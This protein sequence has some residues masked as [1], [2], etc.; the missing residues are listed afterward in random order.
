MKINKLFYLAIVAVLFLTVSCSKDSVADNSPITQEAN[1][2]EKFE[3]ES[4]NKRGIIF[5]GQL[6]DSNLLGEWN[7]THATDLSID[8][9]TSIK[10]IFTESNRVNVENTKD[11]QQC[12]GSGSIKTLTKFTETGGEISVGSFLRS[13]FGLCDPL[14]GNVISTVKSANRYEIKGNRL[15]LF[16]VV[17]GENKGLVFRR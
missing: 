1:I 12:G 13:N 10:I 16:R 8:D 3:S 9:S 14:T 15:A 6:K 17:N 7:L 2:L 4:I 5:P 11:L